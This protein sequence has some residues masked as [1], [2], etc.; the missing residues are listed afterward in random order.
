MPASKRKTLLLATL[1]GL[2]GL[3]ALAIWWL[4]QPPEYTDACLDMG[5]DFVVCAVSDM[6]KVTREGDIPADHPDYHLGREQ[7][8]VNAGEP[9]KSGDPGK[10]ILRLRAARNETV[11]FQLIFRRTGKRRAQDEDSAAFSSLAR[12]GLKWRSAEEGKPNHL[13]TELFQAHYHHVDKGAYT[14]GPSGIEPL[15]WP[16]WYPDALVPAVHQC[17]SRTQV[18]FAEL[19]LPQHAGH[20]QAYWF[21]TYI[22]SSTQPGTYSATL[23]L[24]MGESH[25][26]IPLALDV[27]DA[28]LPDKPSL[29]AV[30]EIYRSYLMEGA[31]FDSS[32]SLWREMSHCYQQ[33][34]H[35]HR[36]VFFERS[37]NFIK[38]KNWDNYRT[39]F[40]PALSGELFTEE[41]GYTGPGENTPVGIWRTPWPQSHDVKMTEPLP[42]TEYELFENLSQQWSSTA[43][44]AGWTETEFFAYIFDEVDGPSKNS[45]ESLDSRRSYLVRVHREMQLMQEALD[46]GAASV[47]GG[48]PIDLIWTSHSNPAIWAGD[49]E[50]DLSGKIRLWAPNGSAAD[51]AFL[52]ERVK[53]GDKAWFYHSGPPALGAHAVNF[54]GV[55]MRTWGVVGARYGFQGQFMWAVNLGNND[56]PFAEPTYKTADDRFG[57]GVVVYPGN[58]LDKIGFEPSPGPLPSVRLKLWRRGLQDAELYFLAKNHDAAAADELLKTI[59]P[60][61]LSQG[62]GTAAWPQDPAEWIEFHK[63]LLQLASGAEAGVEL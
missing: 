40:G 61:A 63:S 20:N 44:G 23:K 32:D 10:G 41:F 26:E 47:D 6:T 49:P 19:S 27:F 30:G 59:M 53:A 11:A 17:G 12:S 34:A 45:G 4:L 1:F 7:A 8:P 2:T 16:A 46:R 39:V 56:K 15:P 18:H 33:L 55:D 5:E 24:S 25:L 52:M 9:G 48:K 58:Q 29:H 22:H 54:S 51:T 3:L 14:W 57:N 60:R 37:P 38:T 62:K 31:G 42:D 35:Q 13:K 36:M 50:L 21:D 28:V 43:V